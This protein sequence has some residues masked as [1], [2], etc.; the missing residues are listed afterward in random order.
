MKCL[1]SNGEILARSQ[2]RKRCENEMLWEKKIFAKNRI[3]EYDA[4]IRLRNDVMNSIYYCRKK[5][6]KHTRY[7]NICSL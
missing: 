3:A 1:P 7:T 4:P 2:Y 6:Y 5:I